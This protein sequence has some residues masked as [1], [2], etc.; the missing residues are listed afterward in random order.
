MP[1]FY[2]PSALEAHGGMFGEISDIHDLK[3]NA[4]EHKGHRDT[5]HDC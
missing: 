4:R 3:A 5:K 1:R 2:L